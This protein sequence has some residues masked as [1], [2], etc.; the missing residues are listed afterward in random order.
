MQRQSNQLTNI[1]VK[2]MYIQVTRDISIYEL[3]LTS[4]TGLYPPALCFCPQICA[5]GRYLG[6]GC[7]CLGQNAHHLAGNRYPGDDLTPPSAEDTY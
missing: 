6:F 4:V 1:S 2:G 5:A 7:W 3:G